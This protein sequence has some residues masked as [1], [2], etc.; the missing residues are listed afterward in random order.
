ML[1]REWPAIRSAYE[2]RLADANFGAEGRQCVGLG[3]LIVRL[4]G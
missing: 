3:A 4:R 1:D 2:V